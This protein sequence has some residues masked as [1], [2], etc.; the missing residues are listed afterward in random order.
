[1]TLALC[2][3]LWLAPAAVQAS[4]FAVYS[5]SSQTLAEGSAVLGLEGN[6]SAKAAALTDALRAELAKRQKTQAQDMTL[7]ELKLTMGCDDS[8]LSCIAEG[9]KSLSVGELIYGKIDGSDGEYTLNLT[10]LSVDKAKISNGL[11]TTLSD[12]ELSSGKIAATATD[13]VNRL[14]GP[15]DSGSGA[16]PVPVTDDPGGSDDPTAEPS[17]ESGE[18]VDE[19]KSSS[20][21]LV[22]GL[23]KPPA[24]WKLIGLGASGGLML[25]SAGTAIATSLL[26]SPNGKLRKD[27]IAAAED[28]LTD[29][30]ARNDISPDSEGD[31][32]EL[33]R[34]E[35]AD[36]PGKVTNASMT[37]ICNKADTMQT[38]SLVGWIGTGVFGLSTAAFTT[39]LF[40][41]KAD[42]EG[43][44]ASFRGKLQKHQVS[45]GYSPR[46]NG[47]FMLG[48]QMRF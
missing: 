18:T 28:S 14:L 20:G 29:S 15:A 48:G 45:L 44:N 19:P 10:V 9:G 26:I 7:E 38:L 30:N 11:T 23:E 25:A 5:A 36:Q 17:D 46:R 2:S 4:P 37:E 34:A 40:V 21:G 16:A 41:R 22:F 6:D 47:G 43:D 42:A 33:A 27:L 39:L 24:K 8:D 35:P 12:D 31:L 13:L 1:L 3:P 32:C